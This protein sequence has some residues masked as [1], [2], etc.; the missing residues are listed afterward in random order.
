MNDVK[1]KITGMTCAH[2]VHAVI[3][4]LDSVAG[5]DKAEVKLESGVAI[6]RGPADTAALIAAVKDA[7]YAAEML[8]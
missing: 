5:V 3:K 2:C 4:A 1:L 7:G 6:V 8:G